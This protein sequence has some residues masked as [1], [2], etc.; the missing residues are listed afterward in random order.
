MRVKA[1][2]LPE[3]FDFNDGDEWI[4]PFGVTPAFHRIM[5]EG[6][7]VDLENPGEN[8]KEEDETEPQTDQQTSGDDNGGNETTV[9]TGDGGGVDPSSGRQSNPVPQGRRGRSKDAKPRKENS[10]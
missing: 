10:K 2:H 1:Q 9:S 3:S 5:K 8:P 4:S 6:K 7:W